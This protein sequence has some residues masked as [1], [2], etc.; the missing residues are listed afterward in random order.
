[1]WLEVEWNKAL[2]KVSRLPTLKSRA[3]VLDEIDRLMAM[4]R[5][6]PLKVLSHQLVYEHHLQVAR[7]LGSL[8]YRL[9]VRTQ[10]K[11]TGYGSLKTISY[12]NGALEQVGLMRRLEPGSA[13]QAAKWR[14]VP[15]G[16]NLHP[17][18]SRGEGIV[19]FRVSASH[20]V[21]R[22]RRGLGKARFKVFRL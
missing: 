17:L 20:D 12:A 9:D 15:R 4:A 8:E 7:S 11:E 10:A 22:H 5:A 18:P 14:V 1:R 2:E 21:W 13:T 3:E 16:N 19:S 6:L